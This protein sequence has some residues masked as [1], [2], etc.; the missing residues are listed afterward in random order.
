VK[1]SVRHVF[2]ANNTYV[3]SVPL[4]SFQQMLRFGPKPYFTKICA[5]Q[6]PNFLAGP[7][8]ATDEP[9]QQSRELVKYGSPSIR[10]V[11][12][13][14]VQSH[15]Q[16]QPSTMTLTCTHPAVLCHQG[17]PQGTTPDHTPATAA[18]SLLQTAVSL[19]QSDTCSSTRACASVPPSQHN[20]S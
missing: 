10:F 18:V 7:N 17:G 2:S 4:E 5:V 13:C 20:H 16:L 3:T 19:L 12:T 6:T 1:G 8:L 14:P 9:L 11:V 15:V